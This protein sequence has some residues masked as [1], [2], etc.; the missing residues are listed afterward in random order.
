MTLAR[1]GQGQELV[2]VLEEGL[3][4][5]PL[6]NVDPNITSQTMA[7][8]IPA[9]IPVVNNSVDLA[10]QITAT[11]VQPSILYTTAIHASAS[12]AGGLIGGAI[13]L[14][15]VWITQRH[16]NERE[17]R[18]RMEEA[19]KLSREERKNV[20]VQFTACMNEIYLAVDT[21]PQKLNIGNLDK[22]F[23]QLALYS[24]EIALIS[25]QIEKEIVAL[26]TPL[27]GVK[28]DNMVKVFDEV[29]AQYNG[30]IRSLMIADLSLLSLPE[31]P[32][33][34]HWWQIRK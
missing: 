20:Y 17:E 13:A 2:A 29:F 9:V 6:T 7:N 28:P 30:R 12:V 10:G 32:S 23:S 14:I 25:P 27:E 15:G 1:R 34:K 5:M 33:T 8:L 18:N 16:S 4:T 11:L 26:L 24:S 31:K 19:R 21:P 3:E 22:M